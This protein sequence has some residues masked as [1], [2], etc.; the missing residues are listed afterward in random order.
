MSALAKRASY[1]RETLHTDRA[2]NA[3][4]PED[5]LRRGYHSSVVVGN[6]V[7]IDSGEIRELPIIDGTP[8]GRVQNVTL[9]LD[10]RKSWTNHSVKFNSIDKNDAP[11]LNNQIIW[12]STDNQT[13]FAFGGAQSYW[14]NPIDIPDVSCWQF[15]ANGEG[16]GSW[17]RFRPV[18][19]SIF[20]GLVRPDSASGVTLDN[21]GFILGG[22]E[23]QKSSP[24]TVLLGDNIRVPGIVSFN[25]TT[26]RWAN[27]T[28]PQYIENL[29]APQV[30][31]SLTVF[32]A[33][34]LIVMAGFTSDRY[35]HLSYNNITIYDPSDKT[36][37]SQ[38]ATGQVP[39]GR[40]GACTV[41]VKGDNNT[42]EIFLYG[43]QDIVGING[44]ISLTQ[45]KE[46]T[47]LDEVYVLSLPAFAWFKAD[48]PAQHPR[49]LH[50]CHAVG[51]R[52]MIS[53]GGHDPTDVYN[54]SVV[55][56][57]FFQGLGIFDLT[58]MRWSDRYD[59]DAE[60]Y[61]TPAV[62]KAWYAEN[63]TYPTQWSTPD[64]QRLFE[65]T[66]STQGGSTSP[67]SPS[68]S[69]SPPK[70]SI[71]TNT[72]AIAGG[73]VGGILALCILASLILWWFRRRKRKSNTIDT[74]D[75]ASE[76]HAYK[77]ELPAK[78]EFEMQDEYRPYEMDGTHSKAEMAGAYSAAELYG[79]QPQAELGGQG[80]SRAER[81]EPGRM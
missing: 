11:N 44:N 8:I 27:D 31:A 34:G 57:P 35:D 48:Y 51:N 20:W 23:D 25:I 64:V 5:F 67:S 80:Q 39:N 13:F 74:T 9:S 81:T 16:G 4:S 18:D 79:T 2:L 72:G 37:H 14:E 73:V 54:N 7:Y 30:V 47:A 45:Y 43:G 22:H 77:S 52:Q 62:V 24:E 78:E 38:I 36:W 32:G 49:I 46:N 10:L 21:T 63:G 19:D 71:S 56:D 70:G 60:A 66:N 41:S 1:S 75:V 29:N 15:T 6:F 26:N 12:P 28:M 76:P 3:P 68:T 55:A 33:D 59:A 53:I 58:E 50:S 61:E 17:S 65:Q 40:T 42:V 69:S